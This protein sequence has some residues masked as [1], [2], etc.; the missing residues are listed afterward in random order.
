MRANILAAALSVLMLFGVASAQVNY[1]RCILL[2]YQPGQYVFPFCF[3]TAH[4]SKID[5]SGIY[6]AS[7]TFES[8]LRPT[9]LPGYCFR[10]SKTENGMKKTMGF[11]RFGF[12]DSSLEL[13]FTGV[14][15][16][17]QRTGEMK[18]TREYRP[19]KFV[20][21]NQVDSSKWR[22]AFKRFNTYDLKLMCLENLDW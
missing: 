12:K 15:V 8:A 17:G 10:T 9:I 21:M 20:E 2:E 16:K 14:N 13:V 3:E 4:A 18:T 7:P 11:T 1:D 22:L 5:G 6:M 19:R